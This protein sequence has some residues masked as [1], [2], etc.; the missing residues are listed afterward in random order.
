MKRSRSRPRVC[1]SG[2]RRS[3]NASAKSSFCPKF[4]K[5]PLKTTAS[6]D[7]SECKWR[8]SVSI[9]AMIFC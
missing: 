4:A 5:S 6:I 9:A 7:V 8:T 3:S 2:I 1:S